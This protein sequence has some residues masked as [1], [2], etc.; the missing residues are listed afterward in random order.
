MKFHRFPLSDPERTKQWLVKIANADM[1]P[2]MDHSRLEG[3]RICSEHF[4]AD[5]YKRDLQA[6]LLRGPP[7]RHL[8]DS[9][10][11]SIF[12]GRERKGHSD[13]AV[14][15]TVGALPLG[16]DLPLPNGDIMR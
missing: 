1:P 3:K 5:D 15:S 4:T 11:P 14:P 16:P 13:D 2:G 10:I 9:A 12:P 8:N 6:E 7:K